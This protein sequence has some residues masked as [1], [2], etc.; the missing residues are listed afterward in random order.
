MAPGRA[1]STVRSCARSPGRR[2]GRDRR[3]SARSRNGRRRPA[4]RPPPAV[5]H[6][7]R[8]RRPRT[9]GF[10]GYPPGLPWPPRLSRKPRRLRCRSGPR[11]PGREA[12]PAA[13][14]PATRWRPQARPP[15]SAP[16]RPWPGTGPAGRPGRSSARPPR[17][18]YSPIPAARKRL[19][20]HARPP[21][22][23]QTATTSAP[24]STEPARPRQGISSLCRAVAPT[25]ERQRCCAASGLSVSRGAA[26]SPLRTRAG[27]TP[28]RPAERGLARVTEHRVRDAIRADR[29]SLTGV[30]S[31]LGGAR[32]RSAARRD[33]VLGGLARSAAEL[34]SVPYRPLARRRRQGLTGY[35]CH[36]AMSG[37]VATAAGEGPAGGGRHHRC[38]S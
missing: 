5:R 30:A 14:V 8:T 21:P 17:P 31:R 23:G 36:H 11:R 20:G 7:R 29:A 26:H 32:C 2:P 38:G 10:P 35:G 37:R 22:C 12:I 15:S 33:G 24:V 4:A 6:R 19:A 3:M 28:E 16:G 25:A 13:S 27:T 18:A 34:P 9:T 1:W